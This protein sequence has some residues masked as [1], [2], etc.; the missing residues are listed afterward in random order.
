MAKKIARRPVETLTPRRGEAQE[1]PDRRVP[2]GAARR[3]TR[4]PIQVAYERAEPRPRP[5]ARLARQGRA[6]LE[7]PRRPRAAALHPG[8]GPPEG[9]DRR[10]AAADARSASTRQAEQQLDLFADFNGIPEGADKTEFY[11]HDAELVEPD[12]PGRL[13]PGDGVAWPSARGC[14][15]RC[16]ASTST[17]PTASSSTSNFQ[18]ST[19]SRDVKDGKAEHIT[20]EPEQVKAFRDTWRDGIHSLPD[21]PARPADRRPRPAH[22][23]GLDLRADRR[24]ECPPSSGADGRGLRRRELR[25]TD[26]VHED[27]G[28][29]A[30]DCSRRS[31][32]TSSGTR[33]IASSVK[34]R[35]LLSSRSARTRRERTYNR[36]R[37]CRRTAIARSTHR[38]ASET[39]RLSTASCVSSVRPHDMTR[40]AFEFDVQPCE[41]RASGASRTGRRH[42]RW[43]DAARTS[44]RG[45]SLRRQD[46]S[47]TC[48]ICDDFP[49]IAHDERLDGHAIGG[50][51]DEKVYVVQTN[52]K[53]VERCILMATDPGD[54]VLDPTCGSGT[55]AYVAEQ[56]GRRWITIDTSRVALALARAR[57]MGARYP[58]YLLADSAEGQLKEAEVTRTAPSTAA[59]ARRHPPRLRLRARA[60]HHAE[61]HR[62]QRRD[63]RDLGEVPG[64]AGA[65]ARE[66]ERSARA[67]H[68]RSGRSR[69][70]PTT[71]WP[72]DGEDS[73]TPSGGSSASPGRRRSTPPSPPRPSSST[74]T[75][76]RTR[77]R[78]PSASP[79][80]SRSRA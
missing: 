14:A 35:Q 78:R 17:R 16:S 22:R 46:A 20:R 60:A 3:A 5:A 8:E 33:R 54:L 13:A 69:A 66:A 51:R 61:V 37:D 64:E 26:R 49:V 72:D 18:W 29:S 45:C 7:R 62:Q 1:H 39:S 4:A 53:V 28:G 70:R 38:R 55:T 34:Y 25:R 12:D 75:T 36:V 74:S 2:V 57:I 67:R 10:P 56:W 79:A 41:H 15:A 21:L 42:R 48:G 52:A 63:R 43:T 30:I 77:T 73:C 23:V 58:Y 50:V 44:S 59:V 19:T 27:D 32:T 47:A 65:A 11:Q 80:R 68:G 9:P 71:Q 40:V 24:R 6:G 31:T 76:S